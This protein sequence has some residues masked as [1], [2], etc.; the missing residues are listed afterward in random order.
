MR[1]YRIYLKNTI[2]FYTYKNDHYDNKI[3]EEKYM[4][5][6]I[7]KQKIREFINSIIDKEITRIQLLIDMFGKI[8]NKDN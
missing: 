1:I 8:F 5:I 4:Y 6:Y 7:S 2:F 3:H